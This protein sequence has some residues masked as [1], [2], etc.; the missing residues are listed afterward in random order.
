[1]KDSQ[2]PAR[3]N[4]TG[5]I[6]LLEGRYIALVNANGVSTYQRVIL[7]RIGVMLASRDRRC[8]GNKGVVSG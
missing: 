7:K 2:E 4:D 1:M 6:D 3:R 8:A 5:L